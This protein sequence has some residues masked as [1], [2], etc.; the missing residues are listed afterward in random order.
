MNSLPGHLAVQEIAYSPQ[1]ADLTSDDD[2]RWHG[3]LGLWK[4]PCCHC[5][6]EQEWNAGGHNEAKMW[7]NQQ[8][9]VTTKHS[10]QHSRLKTTPGLLFKNPKLSSRKMTSTVQ[11]FNKDMST[12]LTPRH[13]AWEPSRKHDCPA[14][15]DA[16]SF[17]RCLL[18]QIL[19]LKRWIG[20]RLLGSFYGIYLTT[21]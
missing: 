8:P 15:F 11:E 4:S 21:N 20:L 9:R 19:T 7:P 5:C 2:G 12:T 1:H 16:P 13:S 18:T 17:H 10:E 14:V 3:G 6:L